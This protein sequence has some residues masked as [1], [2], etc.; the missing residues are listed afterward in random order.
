MPRPYL[1]DTDAIIAAT[2]TGEDA[3]LKTLN[4]RHYPMFKGLKP[5]YRKT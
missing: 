2:A 4:T 5:A 1:V 3:E